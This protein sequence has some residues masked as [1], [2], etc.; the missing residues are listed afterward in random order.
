[1]HTFKIYNVLTRGI[2]Y[3]KQTP[4]YPSPSLRNEHFQYPSCI[5]SSP[6]A[7]LLT[8]FNL[9]VM[10]PGCFFIDLAD[11]EVF[12]NNMVL[13]LQGFVSHVNKIILR[14]GVRDLLFSS[15]ITCV[16]CFL[17]ETWL[18]FPYFHGSRV[19]E[20]G[21]HTLD[22]HT[23]LLLYV[24]AFSGAAVSLVAHPTQCNCAK[25]S[26]QERFLSPKEC[27]S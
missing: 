3:N 8:L 6:P 24:W 10:I 9:I 21:P 1:M 22:L 26:L 13:V 12:L 19:I 4:V 11:T 18:T 27:V 15:C 17:L 23:L 20:F 14:V 2:K 25:V 7:K 16:S 5:L